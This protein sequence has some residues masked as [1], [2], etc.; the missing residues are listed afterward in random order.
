MI[1]FLLSFWRSIGNIELFCYPV[2]CAFL[3]SLISLFR[4]FFGKG[5]SL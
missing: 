2:A 4:S 1:D 5:V 3:W